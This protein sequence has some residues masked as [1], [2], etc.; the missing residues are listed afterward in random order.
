MTFVKKCSKYIIPLS[1]ATTQA[2]C[3]SVGGCRYGKIVILKCSIS[4]GASGKIFKKLYPLP[5][6]SNSSCLVAQLVPALE[7][8][9]C[10]TA[11]RRHGNNCDAEEI[12]K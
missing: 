2:E 12:L 4:L 7:I 1:V 10:W 5:L 9:F 6:G 11:G 8:E 3:C